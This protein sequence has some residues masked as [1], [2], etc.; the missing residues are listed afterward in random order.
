MTVL[1]PAAD[2]GST[3]SPRACDSAHLGQTLSGDVILPDHPDYEAER[4]VWNG[5]VDKRPALIVRC[6]GA[7]DVIAAVAFARDHGLPVSVRGG[8]HNVAGSAV[9]DDGLM[10][11]LSRMKRIKVDPARRVARADAG[12]NLG[13]FDA[14]TQAFGLATTMGINSDTG[15][16]GLTLGGGFGKLGR[17]YGLACDNLL[18]ADIVTA[19]GRLLTAS[20][21]ENPDLFWGIRGG[22]GNFGVVT[23]F[24]YRLHPVGPAV[25]AGSVL[26]DYGQAREALRFYYEF[27]STAPDELSADAALMTTSS[28]ERLFGIS[29]CYSGALDEGERAL[30]PLRAFGSPLEVQIAPTPYLQVQ[31]AGDSV[32]PRGR[33]YYWKAQ[34]LR[35]IS[36]AAIDAVLQ[37]YASAP[38]ALALAVFQQVGGAIARVPPSETAYAQREA[39]YD[40]FPVAI[41]ED[42]A[43]DEA[44]LRWARELWSAMRPFSTGGV[45]VNNLGDEGED[46][47]QAAYG[48]NYPRLV[49]LKD[50]HDPTNLFRLNQN[51][52]PTGR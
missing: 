5:M 18:A 3:P 22:G 39:A 28:G 7:A 50:K 52:R 16:S 13:E 37:A 24:E 46:R 34:F 11:D 40:C 30:A 2:A 25:L 47:V 43:E 29:V 17:K 49:A 6:A 1:T 10:I 14:A 51:I 48:E 4:K 20:P 41:W 42:P 33:R 26:Y 21:S 44:N 12:L 27:S 35:E 23:A 31:S 45:Y 19:D 9:C 15:I 38:S 36:D 32:F 8:G